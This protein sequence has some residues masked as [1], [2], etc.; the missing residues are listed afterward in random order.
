[1][2]QHDSDMLKWAAIHGCMDTLKEALQYGADINTTALVYCPA[3]PDS[4]KSRCSEFLWR[5]LGSATTDS[6]LPRKCS[7]L[8]KYATPLMIAAAAGY[9]E[10]VE[11]LLQHGAR[12]NV[13][14]HSGGVTPLMAAASAGHTRAMEILLAG[15]ADTTAK[16]FAG[17]TALDLAAQ[18]GHAA[19]VSLLLQ[20]DGDQS[21]IPGD[22]AFAYAAQAAQRGYIQ[23]VQAFLDAGADATA[24]YTMYGYEMPLIFFAVD[25]DQPDI[26]S[27]LLELGVDIECRND[28]AET[29]LIHSAITKSLKVCEM[30]HRRGADVNARDM[31]CHSS[32]YWAR[33]RG[34]TKMAEML[35]KYGAEPEPHPTEY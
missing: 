6:N 15:G 10:F 7:L 23:V 12:V 9:T 1:M 28:D 8:E 20:F 16:Q 27:L 32:L 14:G 17:L 4:F 22:D 2:Q 31:D 19:A 29:P 18:E 35:L 5:P 13:A 21:R 33:A 34:G 24:S 26:V 30:L 3:F 25:G 11:T